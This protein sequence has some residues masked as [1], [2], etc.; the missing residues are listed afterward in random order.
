[1]IW[2]EEKETSGLND[3]RVDLHL[4]CIIFFDNPRVLSAAV[5]QCH[6]RLNSKKVEFI[7]SFSKILR[8][9]ERFSIEC[10]RNIILANRNKHILPYVTIR[11]RT[12]TRKTR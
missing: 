3:K 6:N 7:N 11:A 4:F 10:P 9:V 5:N 1:M 12:N 2:S 8:Y